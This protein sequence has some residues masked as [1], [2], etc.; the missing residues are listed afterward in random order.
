MH[1]T[2]EELKQIIKE[3]FSNL[4]NEEEIDEKLFSALKDLGKGLLSKAS[5]IISRKPNPE[6]SAGVGRAF[7]RYK[8]PQKEPAEKKPEKTPQ[9]GIIPRPSTA[10]SNDVIDIEPEIEEP[11]VERGT[12]SATV[13]PRLALPSGKK[14]QQQQ[15]DTAGELPPA[16]KLPLQ[17]PAPKRIGV[18]PDYGSLMSSAEGQDY[19]NLYDSCIVQFSKTP[20]Y[21]QLNSQ[22]QKNASDNINTVLKHL[23]STKRIIQNPTIGPLQEDNT[24]PTPSLQ[25]IGQIDFNSWYIA[26]L[27][28]TTIK[29]F[30]GSSIPD[31]IIK[32]VIGFLFNEGRLAISQRLYNKLIHTQDPRITNN[33]STEQPEPQQES[34]S[35]NNFYNNWKKYTGVKI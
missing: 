34:K 4:I 22:Q 29:H 30:A 2:E 20:Y 35:Y 25:Q 18:V 5:N 7:A 23:V 8:V 13:Q 33:L 16:G 11:G 14:T 10:M 6:A 12:A 3:E 15:D 21:V 28:N 26:S 19:N 1:L 17:L 32:F 9:T 31:E 27:V 24:R